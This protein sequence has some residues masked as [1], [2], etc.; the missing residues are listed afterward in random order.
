MADPTTLSAAEAIAAI[1]RGELG[2]T[3]ESNP[4]YGPLAF[5]TI[6]KYRK[7]EKLPPKIL[8][9]DRFFEKSNVKQFIADAY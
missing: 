7:G 2:A 3:V 8:V 4:R 5:E 1:D 6:E 9:N